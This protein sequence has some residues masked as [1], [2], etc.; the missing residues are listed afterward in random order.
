MIVHCT[1]YIPRCD[2]EEEEVGEGGDA[3]EEK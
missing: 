3:A 1:M 2:V